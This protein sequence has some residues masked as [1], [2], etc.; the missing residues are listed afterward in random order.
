MNSGNLA[1]V[2][3]LVNL[4]WE[5]FLVNALF[6]VSIEGVAEAKIT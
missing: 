2:A 4:R 6:R 5:Y 1:P 3:L